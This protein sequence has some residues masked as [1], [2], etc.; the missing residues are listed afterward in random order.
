MSER[1]LSSRAVKIGALGVV[2]AALATWGF[3]ACDPF[4]DDSTADCVI[5]PD[6][7]G[8]Y[9]VVPD[10]YCDD[11]G[12]TY[13]SNGS[14]HSTFWYYNAYHR[15]G[16]HISGG[17]TLRPKKGGIKTSSGSTIRK[18]GFGGSGSGGS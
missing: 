2:S 17:T 8:D 14:T 16:S 3:V 15:N 9:E 1:R 11:D 13:S 6:A 7:K 4:E 12:G 5:G 18:G 10:R